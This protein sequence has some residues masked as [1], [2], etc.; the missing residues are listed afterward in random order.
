MTWLQLAPSIIA[1][2]LLG[3]HF[4]RSES[5]AAVAI[6]IAMIALVFA[7]WR[8]A[9]RTLQAALARGALEWLRSAFVLVHARVVVGS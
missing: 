3:A 2:V 6:C 9:C 5:Y 1:L 8:W 4:L 7:R